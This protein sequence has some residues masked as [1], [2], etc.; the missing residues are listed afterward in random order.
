[1][2]FCCMFSH[3]QRKQTCSLEVARLKQ[4]ITPQRF[5]TLISSLCLEEVVRWLLC[6]SEPHVGHC[7]YLIWQRLSAQLM[8]PFS[9]FKQKW[10]CLSCFY[11]QSWALLLDWGEKKD[12]N[13]L[14]VISLFSSILVIHE[15]KIW[16]IHFSKLYLVVWEL[17]PSG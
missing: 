13:V 16:L 14:N 11:P 4:G 17:L 2:S 12:L 15:L 8:R 1:M 7:W 6:H 3:Q 5:S 10:V 9:L